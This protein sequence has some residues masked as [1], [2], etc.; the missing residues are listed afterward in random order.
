LW[1][2]KVHALEKVVIFR[3][4]I[5]GTKRLFFIEREPFFSSFPFFLKLV[6]EEL[7]EVRERSAL[8]EGREKDFFCV[9]V[10]MCVHLNLYL[11]P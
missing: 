9:Y 1:R 6:R 3:E 4:I 2:K 7:E 5:F 11:L 8:Q 10:S